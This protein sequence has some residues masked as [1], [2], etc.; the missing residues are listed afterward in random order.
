MVRLLPF[1]G[2]KMELLSPAGSME[3]VIAAVQNGANAVYLGQQ[4]FNARRSAENFTAETLKEAVDY[5]HLRG[6]RVY[7]TMNILV[8]DRELEDVEETLR[9][10]C[11]AG[12]DALIVQDLAVIELARRCCPQMRLHGSTQMTVHTPAGVRFCEQ[13]GLKRVVLARELSLKE[14]EEIAASTTLELEVFAHGALCMS[15]SGQCYLSAMIGTRSGNRGDCAGTC[16]LPFGAKRAEDYDLSLRDLCSI[17]LLGE[18]KRIGVH[19][20]KI[21]GRMK[22]PEYVAAATAAYAQKLRG[23]SPDLRTLEA[24]FSRS[25]FTDGYLTGKRDGSMFGT[26]QK[27][28]VLAAQTVLD[29]LHRSYQKETPRIPVTMTFA[30]DETKSVLT[31]LDE[32]GHQVEVFGDVPQAARTRPLDEE[33]AR[34]SF[35]KLGGTP[36]FLREFS[37]SIAEGLMLPKSKLNELRRVAVEKLS[38]ERLKKERPAFTAQPIPKASSAVPMPFGWVAHFETVSQMPED[39][40]MLSGIGLPLGEVLRHAKELYPLRERLAVELP[41]IYFGEEDRV[42]QALSELKGQGF[43]RVAVSNPGHLALGQEFDME[44]VGTHFLNI[45]NRVSAESYRQAGLSCC[46]LSAELTAK[47]TAQTARMLSY[48]AGVLFYG[49]L[50]LMALRNCPVKRHKRCADCRGE[51]VLTDRRGS[52]FPVLCHDCKWTELLNGQRLWLADKQNDF[53]GVSFGVLYFT[54]ERAEECAK[55]LKQFEAKEAPA[56]AFTRGLFYRGTHE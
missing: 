27:E 42:R 45:T 19:S 49:A 43:T 47:Q 25:G 51:S 52:S 32:D 18:L 38:E 40:S 1:E 48:P 34:A 55:V 31:L 13:L 12:V 16:R 23:Q 26:R 3:S 36:Y 35:E 56:G 28:D 5:C 14:I 2:D 53:S 20:L 41:R 37:A 9:I 7:Q 22:R 10:A 11:E 21:E 8:Y 15:V 4:R 39:C 6:V 44:M 46:T 33:Q 50:P 17:S 30:M 24:V 54:K 29:E